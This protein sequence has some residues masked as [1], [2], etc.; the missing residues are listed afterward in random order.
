MEAICSPKRLLFQHST[1]L[2]ITEYSTILNQP[3]MLELMCMYII[4]A[5]SKP[6]AVRLTATA[7]KYIRILSLHLRCTYDTFKCSR[8]T[9]YIYYKHNLRQPGRCD[10]RSPSACPLQIFWKMPTSRKKGNINTC[11]ITWNI[12]SSNLGCIQFINVCI[13]QKC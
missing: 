2:Y 4:L 6:H 1:Q 11:H 5:P 7:Y 3:Q 10:W 12:T 9:S 8:I 13:K